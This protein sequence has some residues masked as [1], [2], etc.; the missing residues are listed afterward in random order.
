VGI[1]VDVTTVVSS[2]VVAAVIGIFQVIGQRYANRA[3]DHFEKTIAGLVK[4][5]RDA[6][7]D[8]DEKKPPAT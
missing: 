5:G 3:L 4:E 7:R 8:E 6:R 1:N 2:G